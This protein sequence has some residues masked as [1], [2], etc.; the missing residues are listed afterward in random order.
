M[1]GSEL[2]KDLE[3]TQPIPPSPTLSLAVSAQADLATPTTESLPLA[4]KA[5]LC[6][7]PGDIVPLPAGLSPSS[8]VYAAC[9]QI[10]E[11]RSCDVPSSLQQ[12]GQPQ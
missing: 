9:S 12:T 11:L 2:E 1:Y 8:T 10:V 7:I 6:P 4:G 5:L 3:V